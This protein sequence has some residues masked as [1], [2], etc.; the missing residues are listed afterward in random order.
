MLGGCMSAQERARQEA[1]QQQR[2]QQEQ[3]IERQQY[4]AWLVNKCQGFGFQQGTSEFSQCMMQLDQS[5]GQRRA[6]IGAA[7]I[8]SG[9]LN[10][11]LVPM[12]IPTPIQP[13]LLMPPPA[14][15]RPTQTNCYTDRLGYTQCTTY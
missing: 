3:Q 1:L 15:K 2:Y 7:I 14:P 9:M 12:P 11:P 10:R 8:G 13:P 5:E 6:A 4:H